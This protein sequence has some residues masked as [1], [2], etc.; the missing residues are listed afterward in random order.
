QFEAL[1]DEIYW[2]TRQEGKQEEAVETLLAKLLPTLEDNLD[3]HEKLFERVSLWETNRVALVHGQYYLSLRLRKKQFAKALAIYQA[4][5]TLNAQFEPKTP[6][7]ILPLAK[8]AFQEKQYS[9]TLSLLQDFLSRYPKHPDSIEM[10]LLMAKLLTERF[11][12]F[13]EAKAIMAELLENKAHRLYPDIKKYAQFLVKY[14]K[15]FRP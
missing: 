12:R 6:S 11:E 13:D 5:L 10:K 14:S 9:F 3:S 2:L 15:G 1:L 4:C 7:Q 8:Q